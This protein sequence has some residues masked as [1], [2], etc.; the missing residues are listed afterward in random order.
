MRAGAS[1]F[2]NGIDGGAPCASSTR[3]TPL[4]TRR[5]RQ[6]CRAEQ[7]D[8]AGHALDG[9]VFVERADA[10]PVGL[11]DDGVVGRVGDR[12]A[13]GDAGQPRAAPAAQRG[14]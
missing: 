14:G 7:E 5:M 8:V 13:R 3:T 11:G 12:A 6:E 4:S 9:E 2:Q 1:P 10:L